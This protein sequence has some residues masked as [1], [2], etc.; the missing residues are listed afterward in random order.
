MGQANYAASKAG[1]VAFSKESS[2]RIRENI[3]INCVSSRFLKTEM[4]NKIGEEF[5]KTL[6]SRIP[7]GNLGTGEDVSNCGIFSV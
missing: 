1:I 4:T 2:N 6:I 3:N 7:A 5:K